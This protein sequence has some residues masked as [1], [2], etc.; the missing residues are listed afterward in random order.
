MVE[1][2]PDDSIYNRHTKLKYKNDMNANTINLLGAGSNQHA[3]THPFPA[4]QGW[5]LRVGRGLQR[6][7]ILALVLGCLAMLGLPAKAASTE[8]TYQGQLRSSAA[9]ANGLFDLKFSL[10]DAVTAGNQIGT[11]VTMT[12]VTVTNGLF[13]V[14]LDFGTKAFSGPDRWLEISVQPAGGSV[15][16]LLGTRQ[17]LTA[18]PYAL[19]LPNLRTEAS[20]N[21]PT[22]LSANVIGGSTVNT[23]AAG[24]TGVVI[25]GGGATNGFPQIIN[26]NYSV[27]SGGYSNTVAAN[28]S[29]SVIAGGVGNN[30]NAAGVTIGGGQSN[31]GG[32]QFA[33]VGGGNTNTASGNYSTVPG[34]FTNTAS[35]TTSFAAGNRAKAVNNGS[36]V[37][38]D[39]TAADVTSTANDQMVVRANGGVVLN[40]TANVAINATSG[41]TFSTDA[42]NAVTVPVGTHYRDNTIIAWGRVSGNVLSDAFNVQGVV[43]NSAGNYTVTLRSAVSGT[44]LVPVASISYVGG[45]QPTTAANFR[46]IAVDQLLSNSAFN[47]F[48]N[49]GTFAA[50]DSDFTFIVTGR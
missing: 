9:L 6:P 41:M 28:G 14:S 16:T 18:T 48:T 17:K 25:A 10:Y 2:P 8:F 23:V 42:T 12:N 33:T 4:R 38:G 32:G 49:N 43:R 11:P 45:A 22:F 34:G 20:Q 19:A 5:T 30:A 37:W 44:A 31:T 13:T 50:A 24:V 3:A 36:F 40:T 39:S 29:Q 21:G 27:I 47:V 7:A 26:A 46:M 1:M 35:G 15:F